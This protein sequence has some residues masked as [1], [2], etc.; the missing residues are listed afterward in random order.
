MIQ[1]GQ[2]Q[3]T[4]ISFESLCNFTKNNVGVCAGFLSRWISRDMFSLF[5]CLESWLS[6]GQL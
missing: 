6:I 4:N 3:V 2:L 1:L 5:G